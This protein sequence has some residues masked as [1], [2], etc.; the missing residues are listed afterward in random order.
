MA[1][2]AGPASVWSTL[3]LMAMASPVVSASG[4]K[5]G[6]DS[7]R[8]GVDFLMRPI[9]G[10][11]LQRRRNLMASEV[12]RFLQPGQRIRGCLGSIENSGRTARFSIRSCARS[13]GVASRRSGAEEEYRNPTRWIEDVQLCS[14][15]VSLA[16]I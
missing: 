2:G 12:W 11:G 15:T 16:G 14:L 13:S 8:K 10:V 9:S 3:N 5:L 1:A 4:Y 6:T 7:S